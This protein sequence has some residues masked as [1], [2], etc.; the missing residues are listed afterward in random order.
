[1]KQHAFA[2]LAFAVIKIVSDPAAREMV[3]KIVGSKLP[4]VLSGLL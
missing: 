2:G 1:M 4:G 3:N